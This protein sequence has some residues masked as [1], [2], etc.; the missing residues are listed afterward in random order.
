MKLKISLSFLLLQ[1]IVTF[2]QFN[3]PEPTINRP[4]INYPEKQLTNYA[5]SYNKKLKKSIIDNTTTEYDI[6]G[7]IIKETVTD[8]ASTTTTTYTY[9]N[10]VLVEKMQTSIANSEFVKR[11]NAN[12]ANYVK[13]SFDKGEESVAVV[14]YDDENKTNIYRATEDNKNRIKSYIS[15][16]KVSSHNKSVND[17]KEVNII[18][19]K[20][21]II[22]IITNKTEKTHYTYNKNLLVKSEYTKDE[23]SKKIFTTNEYSYDNNNNLILI[24]YYSKGSYNGKDF[25]NKSVQ[26][27]AVYDNRHNIIWAYNKDPYTA[28]N[29]NKSKN[30]VTYKYDSNN[31]LIESSQYE[32]EKQ[33]IKLEYAYQDNLLIKETKTYYIGVPNTTVSSKTYN[34]VNGK[35][36]EFIE[37]NPF[38]NSEKKYVYQYDENNHLKTITAIT[39]Y[40]D[41]NTKQITEIKKVCDFVFDKNSLTFKNEIDRIEKYEFF[42]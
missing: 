31:R 32:N 6:N 19:D 7:N 13:E 14:V 9:K 3:N 35:L 21:K 29:K 30:F 1:S 37:V 27:S 11:E 39:K 40:T 28:Y 17:N 24:K 4:E 5:K 42:E 8:M 38:S 18:Y 26:D 41:R 15:E 23:N 2:G 16:Q 22:D 36:E 12:N 20:D 25:E 34:Y 33:K 10:N